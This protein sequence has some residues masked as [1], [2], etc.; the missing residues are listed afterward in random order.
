MHNPQHLLLLLP[1]S[2]PSDGRRQHCEVPMRTRRPGRSARHRRAGR[3]RADGQRCPCSSGLRLEL[4]GDRL[5]I[6]G[7]DLD[8]T[9][10]LALTVGG[11]TDG[12]GRAAGAARRRHRAFAAAGEGRGRRSISDEVKISGG[13]S[14]FA[15]APAV[16]RRLP[17]AA[18]AGA[19]AV[20]LP[21]A[22][23]GEAL[24]QVVRAA[25]TDEARPILTGVLLT[26]EDDGLRLVATD[27]Y[28]LAVRDLPGVACSAPTRRCSSRHGRCSELQRLLGAGGGAHAAARRARRDVRGRLD[29][30][31]DAADRGRVPELPPADP[32]VVPEHAD[33]RT[34]AA[35][36]GH[37]PGQDPGHGRHAGAPADQRP[38]GCGSRRSR[39]TSATPPTSSTPR[40]TAPS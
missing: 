6:T 13:R 26:A 36:R 32:A 37:P 40:S 12:G 2:S 17:E 10:Q 23:F 38:T 19:S 8:L 11:E 20:T 5:T 30:A 34:R 24:R 35:A 21:A 18:D 25:S 15:R 39:R 3:D 4:A 29:P 22:A 27:S 28:R 33:G 14:Q 16:A 7:T 9:I 1:C 31:H